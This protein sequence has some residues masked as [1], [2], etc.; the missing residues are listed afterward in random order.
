MMC[1]VCNPW[2]GN[3]ILKNHQGC[4]LVGNQDAQAAPSTRSGTRHG[5]NVPGTKKSV[6]INKGHLVL[7]QA[8]RCL[9]G[10]SGLVGES[11][12]VLVVQVGACKC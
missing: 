6:A 4:V 5:D 12:E 8:A 9:V 11:G 3:R 1:N 2:K 7:R 10:K